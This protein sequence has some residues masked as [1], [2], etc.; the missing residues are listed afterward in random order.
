MASNSI[1]AAAG[2]RTVLGF[3]TLDLPGQSLDRDHLVGSWGCNAN[4]ELDTSLNRL[5]EIG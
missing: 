5:V 2:V 1:T 3:N 4:Q